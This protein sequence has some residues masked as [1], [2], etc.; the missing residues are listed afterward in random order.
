MELDRHAQLAELQWAQTNE[1][2]ECAMA[3][4]TL[5]YQCENTYG[6]YVFLRTKAWL[7]LKGL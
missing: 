7:W 3:G 5:R 1:G 4:V 6:Y 2:E